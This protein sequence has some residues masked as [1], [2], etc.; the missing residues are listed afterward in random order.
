MLELKS[1]QMTFS[2]RTREYENIDFIDP[3]GSFLECRLWKS[4]GH[5][6]K[7][8][9]EKEGRMVLMD[10]K[11]QYMVISGHGCV[12]KG[13]PEAGFVSWMRIF[14]DPAKLLESEKEFARSHNS[15]CSIDEKD[16]KIILTIKAKALGNFRNSF[17]LNSSVAES[18]NTRTYTFSK[19]TM[20]PESMEV[21]IEAGHQ[22]IPVIK[23]EQITYN[24][25]IPDSLLSFFPTKGIP[26]I[27]LSAMDSVNRGGIKNISSVQAARLFF[28]AISNRD[29]KQ[30]GRLLP[31]EALSGGNVLKAVL[32]TYHGIR[33]IKLGEAFQSGLY[34][35][36]YVPFV[37]RLPSGDTTSGNLALRRNNPSRAW[38]VDGGY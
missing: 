10:G 2:I 16:G 36:D 17:A 19:A 21:L 1:V 35:G 18:N 27:L 38:N 23:L 5:P 22:H 31:V 28:D 11:D 14:L 29:V 26:V 9:I 4:F 7:W 3:S 30:L 34:P 32:Q 37:L 6:P 12:L 33:L 24:Q 13:S 15:I 8:R 20:L 25:P